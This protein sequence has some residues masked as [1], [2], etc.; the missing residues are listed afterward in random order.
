MSFLIAVPELVDAVASTTSVLPAGAD[1]VSA[2]IAQLFGVHGRDF[3]ALTTRAALFHNEFMSLLSS[4]AAQYASTEATAAALLAGSAAGAATSPVEG[5][6]AFASAV[7]APYQTLFANTAANLQSLGTAISANPLPFLRQLI[8]NQGG[9]LQTAAA[10]VADAVQNLP[11]ALANFPLSIQN[12]VQAIT[13]FQPGALAQWVVNN[14]IGY[15]N[16]IAT[17]L[18]AAGK[19]FM[20][21]LQG[22]PASFQAAGQALQ[23]GD[24]QGAVDDVS[25]GFVNL[26]QTGSN[27]S[28]LK[29]TPHP[30]PSAGSRPSSGN[31]RAVTPDSRHTETPGEAGAWPGSPVRG[32]NNSVMLAGE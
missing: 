28:P 10:A 20:T 27:R 14:Q 32:A 5:L 23:A 4:G 13:N 1:E 16:T 22:L 7:A 3:Q 31:S 11:V 24:F 25:T 29:N 12:G 2:A 26:F 30:S 17:S 21:G 15:F 18:Q 6:V 8:A 19:D 9:Y